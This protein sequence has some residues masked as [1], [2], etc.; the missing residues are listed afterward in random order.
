VILCWPGTASSQQ[1]QFSHSEY[2]AGAD[3]RPEGF[4]PCKESVRAVADSG[5][6]S[7]HKLLLFVLHRCA[8][9]LGS[10]IHSQESGSRNPVLN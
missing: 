6:G 9:A 10:P 5:P 8:S 1:T 4:V 2:P 7:C 3:L